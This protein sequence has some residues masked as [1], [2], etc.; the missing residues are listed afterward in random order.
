MRPSRSRNPLQLRGCVAAHA[1]DAVSGR[2]EG[3]QA[4]AEVTRQRLQPGVM[5]AGRSRGSCAGRGGRGGRPAGPSSWSG[6]VKSGAFRTGCEVGSRHQPT[7][8]CGRSRG[9]AGASRSGRLPP[10]RA[11]LRRAPPRS[12]S[13][14]RP[15]DV[16]APAGA[17]LRDIGEVGEGVE[18]VGRVDVPEPEGADARRVDDPAG[19]VRALIAQRHSVDDDVCRP[20]P[21]TSLTWPVARCACGTS[22]LM[23]VDL[24]TPE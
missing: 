7:Q 17:V 16:W 18:D 21:V 20:R 5:A 12:R 9:A 10:G 4:V 24:P 2:L 11:G 19:S 22:A 3:G 23:S 6:S 13:R 14:A 15:A 8:R 1:E